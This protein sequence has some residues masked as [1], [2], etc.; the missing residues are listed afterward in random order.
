MYDS[1]GKGFSFQA[2][3]ELTPLYSTQ[4]CTLSKVVLRSKKHTRE[5]V[6]AAVRPRL[7]AVARVVAGH[8]FVGLDGHLDAV[9]EEGLRA[10]AVVAFVAEA[11]VTKQEKHLHLE[12]GAPLTVR[13]RPSFERAPGL[14]TLR[15]RIY[16]RRALRNFFL[17]LLSHV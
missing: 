17:R 14:P 7:H 5:L 11:L 8:P 16:R 3:N 10:H 2:T 4:L 9:D 15:C 6:P 13:G 1:I 12:R